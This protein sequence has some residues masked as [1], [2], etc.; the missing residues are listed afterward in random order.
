MDYCEYK[1]IA[2]WNHKQSVFEFNKIIKKQ[3]KNI[4][5]MFI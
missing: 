2:H 4:K 5:E 1:D 3:F